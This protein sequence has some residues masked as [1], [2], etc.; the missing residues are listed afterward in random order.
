MIPKID[1]PEMVVHINRLMGDAMHSVAADPAFAD[2]PPADAP[3]SKH[4]TVVVFPFMWDYGPI[5][6]KAQRWITKTSMYSFRHALSRII[7][8]CLWDHDITI[9]GLEDAC[10]FSTISYCDQRHERGRDFTRGFSP[11]TRQYRGNHWTTEDAKRRMKGLRFKSFIDYLEG[12]DWGAELSTILVNRWIEAYRGLEKRQLEEAERKKRG[13]KRRRS[14][15]VTEVDS[16]A[17][18]DGDSEYK[19]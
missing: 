14:R 5:T 19:P 17:E 6:P 10:P 8:S 3:V 12:G 13:K 18:D 2:R 11:S 4:I 15:K 16:E 9:V 1:I 7:D